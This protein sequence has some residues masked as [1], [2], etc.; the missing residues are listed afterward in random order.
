MD[1]VLRKRL[2]HN[3]KVFR[4][5]NE[6]IDKA[7]DG[8]ARPYICECAGAACTDVIRLT[9]DEYRRIRSQPDHYVIVPGHQVPG[10]EAVVEREPDHLV[11]DKG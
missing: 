11:V 9:A 7:S 2:E 4:A 6:E 8:V 3:E 10:L 1:E 5:V